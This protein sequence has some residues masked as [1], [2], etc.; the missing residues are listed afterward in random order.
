LDQQAGTFSTQDG[1]QI[2]ASNGSS[3]D[4]HTRCSRWTKGAI[5]ANDLDLDIRILIAWSHD[6]Q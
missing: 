5:S 6:E 2:N 3:T 4:R 1:G